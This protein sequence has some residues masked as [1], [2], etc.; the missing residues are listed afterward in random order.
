MTKEVTD[1]WVIMKAFTGTQPD[2]QTLMIL[3]KAHPSGVRGGWFIF[4]IIIQKQLQTFHLTFF[5]T[6][7]VEIYINKMCANAT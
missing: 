7:E 6:N 3:L 1:K 4:F 2:G 5:F